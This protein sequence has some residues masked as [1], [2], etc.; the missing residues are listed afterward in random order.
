MEF[1]WP[2]LLVVFRNFEME[3]PGRDVVGDEVMALSRMFLAQ[4]GGPL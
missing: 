1:G 4:M 3:F 2:A